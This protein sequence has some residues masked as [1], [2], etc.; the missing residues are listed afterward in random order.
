MSQQ[1]YF[2]RAD[3]LTND[4]ETKAVP[5]TFFVAMICAFLF[6]IDAYLRAR[7]DYIG[8]AILTVAMLVSFSPR[9]TTS[10]GLVLLF[11]GVSLF[12]V[13][14]YSLIFVDA[15]VTPAWFALFMI[16]SLVLLR[17]I[18][19]DPTLPSIERPF[20]P[21]L[22]AIVVLLSI[23]LA[24]LAAG[25][26]EQF[27]SATYAMSILHLERVHASTK[28]IIPRL[29]GLA[30]LLIALAI[31]SLVFWSGFGRLILA[32]FAL[33][34]IFLAV[35][36]RTFRLNVFA[37]SAGVGALVFIGRVIRFGWSDGVAGLADDSGASP[38]TYT[39]AL[40]GGRNAVLYHEPI[41]HQW[42]L[43]FLQPFPRSVWPDKP[44]GINYTFVDFFIGREG[45]GEEHSTAI[46]LFGEHIFLAGDWWAMSIA[47]LTVVI[48]LTSRAVN[49]AGRPYGAPAL[50]F[51]CWLITLFWGGMAD[52]GSRVW[53]GVLPMLGY[54]LVLRRIG[55]W[56]SSPAKMR[57]QVAQPTSRT[58]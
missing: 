18:N 53:F 14:M 8:L 35:H 37:F 44:I 39:E 47:L 10:L 55:P 5:A 2:G 24:A 4:A 54:L 22:F 29:A 17:F 57:E 23:G 32:S 46:G 52:F 16:V 3:G 38:L 9:S 34:P 56:S 48:I 27:F 26:I 40:W 1:V 7:T 21:D 15:G 11:S 6:L 41:W 43:L 19:L 25:G 33:A 51:N 28:S 30:M 12:V 20:M 13:P 31:Y 58:A 49:W 36:Y 42:S 50:M 45:L